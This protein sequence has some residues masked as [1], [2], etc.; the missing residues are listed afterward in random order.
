M[1]HLCLYEA[2]HTLPWINFCF[3]AP[4]RC[5]VWLRLSA[6]AWVSLTFTR[7]KYPG[8]CLDS[9]V[10]K[11]LIIASPSAS[12]HQAQCVSHF[13]SVLCWKLWSLSH[14]IPICSCL[15]SIDWWFETCIC[16]NVSLD[17]FPFCV[18]SGFAWWLQ[19][20]VMAIVFSG[21][22]ARHIANGWTDLCNTRPDKVTVN[23]RTSSSG[24]QWRQLQLGVLCLLWNTNISSLSYMWIPASAPVRS[25]VM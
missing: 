25:Q 24:F 5:Q 6:F 8:T 12:R 20:Y 1:S 21:R 3:F 4:A 14:F 11:K 16:S 9:P 13:Q 17:H 15:R 23:L 18:S 10:N 7:F 2:R 19:N 22:R